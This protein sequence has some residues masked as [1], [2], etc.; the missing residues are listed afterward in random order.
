MMMRQLILR[1]L[2]SCDMLRPFRTS[3]IR[4]STI[5]RSNIRVMLLLRSTIRRRG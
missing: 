5:R 1:L 4:R 3:S 2:W